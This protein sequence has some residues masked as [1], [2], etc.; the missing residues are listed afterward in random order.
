M[1]DRV[2]GVDENGP[3]AYLDIEFGVADQQSVELKQRARRMTWENSL[4]RRQR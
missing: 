2:W 1:K 3:Y 4:R